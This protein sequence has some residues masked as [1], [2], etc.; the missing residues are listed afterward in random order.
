MCRKNKDKLFFDITPLL[1]MKSDI[2]VHTMAK[3]LSYLSLVVCVHTYNYVSINHIT[4]RTWSRLL[5]QISF[6][7][8]HFR[9]PWTVSVIGKVQ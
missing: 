6:H 7:F 4:S 1:K 5:Q 2:H 8:E 3:L 9:I